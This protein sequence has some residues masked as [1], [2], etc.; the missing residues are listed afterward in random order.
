MRRSR[1]RTGPPPRLTPSPQASSS[2]IGIL[3]PHSYHTSALAPILGGVGVGAADGVGVLVRE[4]T[5]YMT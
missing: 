2:L 4:L 5:L 3:R 1:R